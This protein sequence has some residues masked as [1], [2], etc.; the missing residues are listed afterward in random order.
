M[1]CER[2]SALMRTDPS[3]RR[4]RSFDAV[5]SGSDLLALEQEQLLGLLEAAI[6]AQPEGVVFKA[7]WRWGMSGLERMQDMP[8]IFRLVR[9]RRGTAR[10]TH[11]C[12]RRS[13]WASGHFPV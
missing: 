5:A 8:R 4:A 12:A 6:P 13:T 3:P 9:V 1:G 10:A 2:A 11:G 7:A